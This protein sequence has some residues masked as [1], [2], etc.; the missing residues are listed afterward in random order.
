MNFASFTPSVTGGVAY[1]T[2]FA[3]SRAGSPT[4]IA[5]LSVIM[6]QSLLL[7]QGQEARLIAFKYSATNGASEFKKAGI[8]YFL[9]R[10]CWEIL[11]VA[12]TFLVVSFEVHGVDDAT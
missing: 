12:F 9:L 10:F 11:G 2:E 7:H 3:I 1:L 8:V 5:E 4:Q 6:L